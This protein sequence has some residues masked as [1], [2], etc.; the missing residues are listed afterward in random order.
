MKASL[1][2]NALSKHHRILDVEFEKVK[3]SE[4]TRRDGRQYKM[5]WREG[6]LPFWTPSVSDCVTLSLDS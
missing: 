3:D 4:M 5:E 6:G 1:Q 2:F